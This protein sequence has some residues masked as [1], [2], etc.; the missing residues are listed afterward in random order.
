MMERPQ[1]SAVSRRAQRGMVLYVSLLLL[2]ALTLTGL[3]V[4]R[5]ITVDERI[6]AGQRDRDLAFQ[7]AEAA[8]R[9]GEG[10]LD[11]ASAEDLDVGTDYYSSTDS[12]TWQNADWTDT[13]RDIALKTL[14]YRGS[15]DP[16]PAHPPRFYIV[17]TVQADTTSD[18]S[19]GAGESLGPAIVFEVVAKGWGTSANNSVV[20]ESTYE[21]HGPGTGRRLSWRQ[22]Q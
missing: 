11:S 20:L 6:A 22:L 7:A 17:R 12:I 4:S 16:V 1:D 8:L 14:P 21:W 15:L 13:S 18:T 2:L 5:N 19:V 3:A 9:D 10:I